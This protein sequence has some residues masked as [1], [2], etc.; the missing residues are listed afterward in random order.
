MYISKETIDLIRD[1]CQIEDIVKR[2]VPTLKK[3]G[4]NYLGLCPFHKEKTP[5]F[6]VSTDKQIFYCFGCKEGEM[7]L[8]LS[9]KLNASI[10]RKV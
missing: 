8:H 9:I 5:S 2:Y 7:Y 1:R 10:F 4:K 6:T 3:K